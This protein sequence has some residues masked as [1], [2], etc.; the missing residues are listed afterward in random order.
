MSKSHE[1]TAIDLRFKM[2]KLLSKLNERRSRCAAD[3]PPETS[4]TDDPLAVAD[5][6]AQKNLVEVSVRKIRKDLLVFHPE[7]VRLSAGATANIPR[8]RRPVS[9]KENLNNSNTKPC[10]IPKESV[11][12]GV[13]SRR[14]RRLGASADAGS[15]G[16]QRIGPICYSLKQHKK[17]SGEKQTVIFNESAGSA[18]GGTPGALKIVD[19][20][21]SISIIS[22]KSSRNNP[23]GKK[24]EERG[25][26]RAKMV[27]P[28]TSE[29]PS[30]VSVQCIKRMLRQ[31]K[32][33]KGAFGSPSMRRKNFNWGTFDTD[34]ARH[35]FSKDINNIHNF[36]EHAASSPSVK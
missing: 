10:S 7:T 24:R 3:A 32:V 14:E 25:G 19:S 26:G 2:P 28:K 16:P 34:M 17:K 12:S 36:F 13:A 18:S 20:L 22:M 8:Q 11:T 33:N 30:L 23:D 1:K 27:R 9:E 15:P 21:A 31:T 29:K 6:A 35:G 5:R 4:L